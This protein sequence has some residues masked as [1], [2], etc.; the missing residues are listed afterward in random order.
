M[1]RIVKN[2]LTLLVENSNDDEDDSDDESPKE[3]KT[4]KNKDEKKED[5]NSSFENECIIF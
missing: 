1:K 5:L 3:Q 4:K 2:C